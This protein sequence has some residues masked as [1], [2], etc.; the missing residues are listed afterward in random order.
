[1]YVL[2]ALY[3]T[4]PPLERPMTGP[5]AP[6]DVSGET[7]EK[8]LVELRPQTPEPGSR[9]S[10][11]DINRALDEMAVADGSVWVQLVGGVV[12]QQQAVV[13]NVA[14]TGESG[15]L[16]EQKTLPVD[17]LETPR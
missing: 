17:Q 5:A 2:L 11:V 13:R 6:V 8:H 16:E 4:V 9:H 7:I 10:T 12:Q 3:L 14:V 1:M 15:G